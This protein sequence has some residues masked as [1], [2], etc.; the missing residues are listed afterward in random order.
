MLI[1]P[2]ID[3]IDGKCVRLT[4]GDYETST[5]YYE[6]PDDAAK[7]WRD[8]GAKRIHIVDLEG[9]KEGCLVN[10]SSIEKIRK[11]FDKEIE[12]G[13]GIRNIETVSELFNLGVDYI[14]LGSIAV[15]DR[16][17]LLEITK[18]YKDR[19]IIGIDAKDGYVATK[20]WLE[21]NHIKDDELA[22][23]IKDL[24][25]S[26]VIY[27]D[28]KKDGMMEGPNF[29]AIRNIINTQLN[30]IA[31]GGIASL[32]DILRLKHIGAFGAIIGKALY[33]GRINLK[34]VLEVIQ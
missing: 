16:R 4:M 10:L 12:V 21:R 8:H 31:S 19:I 7:A 13:G 26:T 11:A 23:E 33:T 34:D 17:L 14:I 2:A 18:K 28:I 5:V 15:H 1:I 30:V 24:G 6:S 32:D 9:A 25:L 20:G 3:I 27:T 22:K 29:D